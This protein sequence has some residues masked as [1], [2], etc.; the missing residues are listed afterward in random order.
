MQGLENMAFVSNA[1]SLV[2]Y[3]Y[4]YMNFS[5]T[6]SA[7]TLTNFMETSFLLALF[8]GFLSDTYLT[9]FQTCAIFGSIEFLGNAIPAIQ[10]HFGVLRPFPCIEVPPSK[11]NK[12]EQASS[13]Q[14]AILFTGLYPVAFG[15]SGIKGL[16][17]VG[18]DWAFGVSTLAISFAVLFLCMGKSVY[19]IYIPQG[20]PLIR[21]F[22]VFVAAYKNRKLPTPK[23][24]DQLFEMHDRGRSPH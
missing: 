3:F 13:G 11:M 19:R 12:C 23:M 5:L 2:T 24:A 15:S 14:V 22:Q 7:T 16:P 8:G 4:G 9:R 18:V 20:S 17:S 21:I 6:K 1:V 10:A